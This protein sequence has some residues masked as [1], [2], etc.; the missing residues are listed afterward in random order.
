LRKKIKVAITGSIGSGKS[1]FCNLVEKS[2]FRVIR[3]DQL[4]KELLAT[5][6]EIKKKVIEQFGSKSY[7]N[8]IPDYSYLAET[9]FNDVAKLRT[10]ESILHPIVIQN[11]QYLSTETFYNHEIVFIET[12]LVYESDIE[13]L[14]D[15]VV[16]I[17]APREIRL[18]RKIRSGM[19]EEDF[20]RREANQIPDKEKKKRADFVFI[21]DKTVE[22]LEKYFK[23]LCITLGINN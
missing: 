2:G 8:N 21:N 18:Q 5:N 12:A 19:S 20:L 3:A 23:I 11:I 14:F 15:Y 7:N 13:D 16:L 22:D 4:S 1:E 6:D 17:T 9:V 10:L